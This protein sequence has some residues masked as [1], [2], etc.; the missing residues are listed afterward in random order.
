MSG[1]KNTT[2]TVSGHHH[3]GGGAVGG[4]T[5]GTINRLARGGAVDKIDENPGHAETYPKEGDR[6]HGNSATQRANP[7][8]RELEDHGG[9]T[10]LTAG[11]KKG[12]SAKHFHVHKHFHAKGG[13][14]TTRTQSYRGHEKQAETS[15]EGGSIHDS[16]EPP[17]GGPDYARGGRHPVHKNAGGAMYAPGGA[18]RPPMSGGLNGMQAL[19]APP[20][21]ALGRLAM[22][23]QGLPQRPALPM[24]RPMAMPG[25]QP[26]AHARGGAVPARR[27]AEREVGK[28]ERK[29]PPRGHGMK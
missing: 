5:G 13:K 15:A 8:T 16:T 25:P 1:F 6:T 26:L 28:H 4:G 29:A 14:I 24:R 10:P 3:W 27:V 20:Q 18:V 22:R 11:F 9:K 2:R 7:P 17:A 12:G 23:P 19:Q 21:G